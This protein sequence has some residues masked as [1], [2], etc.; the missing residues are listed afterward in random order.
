MQRGRYVNEGTYQNNI[1]EYNDLSKKGN[2]KYAD[3][4]TKKEVYDNLKSTTND[5]IK[6]YNRLI[7]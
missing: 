2:V 6:R 3:F 4:E 1:D 5:D 7:Q